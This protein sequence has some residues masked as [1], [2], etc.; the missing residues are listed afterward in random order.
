MYTHGYKQCNQFD[1]YSVLLDLSTLRQGTDSNKTFETVAVESKLICTLYLQCQVV[2]LFLTGI[3][4][5]AL[6][7]YSTVASMW[8]RIIC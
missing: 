7:M 4:T 8:N 2:S 6:L 5:C 3:L 1:S